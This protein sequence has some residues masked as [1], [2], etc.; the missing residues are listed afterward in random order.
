MIEIEFLVHALLDRHD[1]DPNDDTEVGQG[2][3]EDSACIGP[4]GFGTDTET[5]VHSHD[6][7]RTENDSGDHKKEGEQVHEVIEEEGDPRGPDESS[8]DQAKYG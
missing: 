3:D 2:L 8:K 4:V 5:G 7:K 1:D 6:E